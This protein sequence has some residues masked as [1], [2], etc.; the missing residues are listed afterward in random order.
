LASRFPLLSDFCYMLDDI[1]VLGIPF[2]F[3]SF[4]ARYIKGRCLSCIS[5]FKVK[6]CLSYFSDALLVFCLKTFLFVSLFFF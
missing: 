3:A 2:V 4:C 1:K 6:G 5:A